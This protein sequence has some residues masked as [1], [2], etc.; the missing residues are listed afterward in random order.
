MNQSGALWKDE[1]VT[2]Q[3]NPDT[4]GK[5]SMLPRRLDLKFSYGVE[6]WAG[7]SW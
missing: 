2:L 6:A 5:A 7:W 4:D 3:G 1:V